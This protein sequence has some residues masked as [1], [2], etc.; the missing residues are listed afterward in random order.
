[1]RTK[2]EI[3]E[4]LAENH[5]VP[6]IL[7]IFLAKFTFEESKQYLRP[8]VTEEIFNKQVVKDDEQLEVFIGTLK[9]SVSSLLIG[10]MNSTLATD[11]GAAQWIDQMRFLKGFL[12]RGSSTRSTR[13]SRDRRNRVREIRSHGSVGEPVGNHRLYP[14]ATNGGLAAQGIRAPGRVGGG[15]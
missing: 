11:S 10:I 3:Q 12:T 4:F 15:G 7:Q 8:D 1:M 14:D 2:E 9:N 5:I 6:N 13:R